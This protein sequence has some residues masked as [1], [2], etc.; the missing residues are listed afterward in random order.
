MLDKKTAAAV[1]ALT[2]FGATMALGA[3]TVIANGSGI[4]AGTK[5]AVEAELI[6]GQS[7][8]PANILVVTQG[9]EYC[10]R[11]TITGVTGYDSTH[12]QVSGTLP[13]GDTFD[14]IAST[15]N[16]PNRWTLQI[17]GNNIGNNVK[18]DLP[19]P[20]SLTLNGH[21]QITPP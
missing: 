11:G 20:V 4:V 6:I 2:L 3:A 7:G 8:T 12:V 9:N 10:F 1:V 15:T 21:L 19:V 5:P 18:C 16:D 14:A 13:T 17:D